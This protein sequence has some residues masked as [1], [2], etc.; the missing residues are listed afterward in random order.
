MTVKMVMTM[1]D[2]KMF[3]SAAVSD[4]TL[5]TDYELSS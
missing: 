1:K 4:R 2:T 5:N 3:F